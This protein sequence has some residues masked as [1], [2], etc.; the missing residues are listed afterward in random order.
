MNDLPVSQL[1]TVD[2]AIAILD[3]VPVQPRVVSVPLLEAMGMTLAEEVHAE[4]DYPPFNRA[5]MDGFAV[6]AADLTAGANLNVIETIAAGQVGHR[7]IASGEAAAIMTGAPLPAGS[8]AVLPVELVTRRGAIIS[9]SQAIPSGYAVAPIGSDAP[10][11]RLLLKIGIRLGPAQLGVAATVGRQQLS[12]FDRPSVSI[13]ATGDELIEVGQTPVGSQIRNSNSVML[14]AL[15]SRLGYRVRDLGVVR[16]EPNLIRPAIEAGLKD[17]C[18]FITG[19]MSMGERDYVPRL[20]QEIGL[21]LKISK[22]RIKPGKPFVFAQS[23]DGQTA[24]G[25]PG[26]PVSAFVCTLRLANR[27]L[28]RQ[29]G[30][31]PPPLESGILRG[32]LPATGPREVYRPARRDGEWVEPLNPNGSADLFT[33]A[34]ADCLV[35]RPENSPGLEQGSRVWLVGTR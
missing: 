19:G 23:N 27:L 8:D 32:N 11:G 17:D 7:A 21:E 4:R 12:V 6:R 22:L 31:T 33:L 29:A 9:A 35:V 16:D 5:L 24:F 18:L 3:A 2:Q 14:H 13:L 25:L 26:N 15:L 28:A 10:A 34:L 20:L 1:L 30:T